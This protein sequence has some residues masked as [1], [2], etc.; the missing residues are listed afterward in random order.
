MAVPPGRLDSIEDHEG[1]E[2]TE[3][4]PIVF[5]NVHPLYAVTD[6]RGSSDERN[7]AVQADL[8]GTSASPAR[9]SRPR[10]PSGRSRFSTS[11]GTAS[12]GTPGSSR[13]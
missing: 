2:A 12:S 9:S 8:G 13:T 6:I 7:L 3:L 10:P 1:E 4:E 11:S 5:R